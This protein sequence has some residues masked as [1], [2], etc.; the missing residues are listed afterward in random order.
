MRVLGPAAI[1]R[2]AFWGCKQM[3]KVYLADGVSEL[4]DGC[5]DYCENLDEVFIPKTVTKVTGHLSDQNGPEYRY[6]TFRCEHKE[7]PEGWPQNW[8]EYYY[9]SRFGHIEG[10]IWRHIVVWG[11][12]RDDE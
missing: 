12:K 9:D 6:P 7:Q 4:N 5:F 11:C 8:H 10:H 1:E 3:T 2:E